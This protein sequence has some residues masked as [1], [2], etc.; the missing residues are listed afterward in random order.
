MTSENRNPTLQESHRHF[1]AACFNACWDLIE[2]ADR[3]AEE[4]RTMVSLAMASRWH[5]TQVESRK[6]VNFVRSEWQVARALSLAGHGAQAVEHARSGLAACTEHGIGGFD[7]AFAHEALARAL[8]VT[9]EH[10]E[11]ATHA[12]LAR[13]AAGGIA[14]DDDREHFLKE[15]ATLRVA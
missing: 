1:A 15:L 13:E 7:L 8:A 2:K 12:R 5:W 10:A 14:E 9:G 3:T 4:T 11:A 6:P